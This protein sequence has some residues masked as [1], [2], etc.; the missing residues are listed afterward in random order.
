MKTERHYYAFV[1]A[2]KTKYKKQSEEAAAKEAESKKRKLEESKVAVE[3]KVE[4][5]AENGDEGLFN[6]Y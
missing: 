3:L 6:I 4:K 2:C 1:E 5:S